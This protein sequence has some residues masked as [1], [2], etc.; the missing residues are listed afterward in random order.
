MVFY[1]IKSTND[2]ITRK[3]QPMLESECC[4]FTNGWKP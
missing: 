4:K 2:Y 1:S 3:T